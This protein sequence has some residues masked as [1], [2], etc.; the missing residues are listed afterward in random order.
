[1]VEAG[2]SEALQVAPRV[3]VQAASARHR[4]PRKCACDGGGGLGGGHGGQAGNLGD[5]G[6]AV[7][8]AE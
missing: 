6:S 2:C 4:A 1:M 8:V 7:S 3:I 5:K